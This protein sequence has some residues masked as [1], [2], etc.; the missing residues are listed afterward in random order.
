MPGYISQYEAFQAKGVQ[1]I[2]VVAVNDAFVMQAWKEKLGAGSS[3]VHFL[4]DDTGAFT[5]SVGMAFDASGLLGN[6]RSKRYAIITEDGVV[7]KVFVEDEAPTV[8]RT[9]VSS[10]DDTIRHR[11]Q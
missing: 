1:G 8:D 2:Y 6:R 4:A 9:A 7:K 5:A 3:P 11:A 10:S